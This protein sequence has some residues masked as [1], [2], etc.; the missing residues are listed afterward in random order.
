MPS[1]SFRAA[2][3]DPRISLRRC[4]WYRSKVTTSATLSEVVGSNRCPDVSDGRIVRRLRPAKPN[5]A[6]QGGGKTPIYVV[7]MA[8]GLS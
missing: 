1:D 7:Q 3:A 2:R 8:G 5:I 4:F 6:L